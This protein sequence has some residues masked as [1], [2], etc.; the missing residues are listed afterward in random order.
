MII[1]YNYYYTV[2]DAYCIQDRDQVQGVEALQ[3]AW[4]DED[5]DDVR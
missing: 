4:H 1:M 2:Y 5:D 3:R